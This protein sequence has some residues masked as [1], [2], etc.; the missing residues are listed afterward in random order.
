MKTTTKINF[1]QRTLNNFCEDDTKPTPTYK[2]LAELSELLQEEIY[3]LGGSGYILPIIPV[4]YKK[5]HKEQVINLT[6]VSC[7]NKVKEFL[8]SKLKDIKNLIRNN[9]NKH[10]L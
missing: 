9:T 10:F 6:I 7:R 1:Y 5:T 2:A 4:L 3:N 8:P